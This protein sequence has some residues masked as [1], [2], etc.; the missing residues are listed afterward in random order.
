MRY[1]DWRCGFRGVHAI[2]GYDAAGLV[3]SAAAERSADAALGRA[4]SAVGRSYGTRVARFPSRLR[5]MPKA[6]STLRSAAA[7][8]KQ[9]QSKSN[10]IQA[11]PTIENKSHACS[12]SHEVPPSRDHSHGS[13]CSVHQSKSNQ[14][15]PDQG[16][17]YARSTRE[18]PACSLQ[19]KWDRE[20]EP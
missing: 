9:R 12:P 16:S 13:A 2:V 20:I 15:K 14:I 7:L 10:L 1:E 17:R 11:N 4:R 5:R 8:Q 3:W 19:P 18:A 6:A